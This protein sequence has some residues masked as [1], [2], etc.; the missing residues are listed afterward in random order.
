MTW[1]HLGPLELTFTHL[2]S[3]ELTGL[4]LNS[5]E[6]ASTSPKQR[7]MALGQTGAWKGCRAERGKGKCNESSWHLAPTIH[8]PH[9]GT[10][11]DTERDDCPVGLLPPT[12]DLASQQCIYSAPGVFTDAS[13]SIAKERI[14]SNV[15]GKMRPM[16]TPSEL[17]PSCAGRARIASSSIDINKK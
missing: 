10:L 11:H 16:T 8:P 6:L 1:T 5:H 3:H 4:H 13:A 9:A 15:G 17:P 14:I 2:T 12:S 7:E